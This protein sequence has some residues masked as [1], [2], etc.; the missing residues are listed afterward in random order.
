MWQ[1]LKQEAS[2]SSIYLEKDL[3]GFLVAD[4]QGHEMEVKMAVL[5]E[6][7]PFGWRTQGQGY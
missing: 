4:V 3:D 1:S 5:G 7:L 6:I 2:Q